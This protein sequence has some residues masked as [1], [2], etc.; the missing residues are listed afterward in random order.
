[1][2]RRIGSLGLWMVV[3]CGGSPVSKSPD[4][5]SAVAAAETDPPVS[6]GG[7]A[8]GDD[9]VTD[10]VQ[11]ADT[12]A[13]PDTGQPE[14]TGT[15]PEDTGDDP[16]PRYHGQALD[17]ALPLPD[18]VVSDQHGVAHGPDTLQGAPTVV[19]F[20]RDTANACTNDLLGAAR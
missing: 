12:G 10:T 16:G 11:E 14:D 18:F 17:P 7:D 5:A 4:A 20:F 8:A 1:M 13:P 9:G 6:S 3:G 2:M 15:E 19:W